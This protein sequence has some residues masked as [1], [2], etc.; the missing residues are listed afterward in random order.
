MH[1]QGVSETGC[2][3]QLFHTL[4]QETYWH[5]PLM[6]QQWKHPPG[7][8]QTQNLDLEALPPLA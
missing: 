6:E 7:F 3:A 8:W 2:R 5:Y 1:T 4:S